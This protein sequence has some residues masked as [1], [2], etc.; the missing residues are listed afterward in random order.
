MRTDMEEI[1]LQTFRVNLLKDSRNLVNDYLHVIS[2]DTLSIKLAEEFIERDLIKAWE[3]D[4][5]Y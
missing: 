5:V 4:E 1:F 3:L 2:E